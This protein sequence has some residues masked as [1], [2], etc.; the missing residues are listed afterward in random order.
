MKN[1]INYEFS[2]TNRGKKQIIIE[3]KYKFN[4]TYKYVNNT[5]IYRCTHYKT[6]YKC[7][8]F[9]ILNDKDK[10][11]KYKNSHNHLEEKYNASMS[12]LKHGINKE[13][14]KNIT[15]TGMKPKL[16]FNKVSQKIGIICPDFNSVRTQIRRNINKQYPSD[17][18]TFNEI[19]DES[20]YF[21][22]VRSEDFM[23]FKNSNVVICQ[24]PFQAKIYSKY[25]EDIFADG[26]FSIVPDIG[27]QVF[28]TRNYVKEYNCFYTTSFSIL[29]DKKQKTYE[30]LLKEINKNACK[31]NNNIIIS[32][33]KFHCDFEKAIS[34]AAKKVFPNIKIKLCVW[35]Y[36]RA[37]ESNKN[38]I[39]NIE[40]DANEKDL[41]KEYKAISNLPFINPEY[42]VEIYKEIKNKCKTNNY[43]QF[44]KFLEYFEE[45]YLNGYKINEWNYYYCIEHITNN[46]SES[47]NK[48]LNYLIPTKPNFY[49]LVNILREEENASFL[50]YE[51]RNDGIWGKKE[52]N[53]SKTE[54]I[55][56]LIEKYKNMESELIIKESNRDVIVNLWF[57]CLRELN[58]LDR[59]PNS[60]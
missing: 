22:T 45:N 57:K 23:I 53:L 14:R 46:A 1:T 37:L 42:I 15:S 3:R 8:S 33:I 34:N 19:P 27:Y 17:V 28:I 44:L 56:N 20:Q 7:P 21:K 25:N 18:K 55:N 36:K 24:S 12:L 13:I 26:T 51:R 60:N 11:I 48:Y 10:I 39:C 43:V 49:K 47:F 41:Y 50:D 59:D 16:L 2:E 9:V 6:R 29:K 35:H 5:T 54:E 38:H 40:M 32:P 4:Y 52:K 31:Y 30:I 58:T